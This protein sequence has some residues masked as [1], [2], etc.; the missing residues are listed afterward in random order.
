MAKV[1]ELAQL[2]GGKVLGDAT[3]V[4]RG[5][6]DLASAGEEELSFLA[7]PKYRKAFLETRAGAVL[8][9]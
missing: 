2:V 6:A 7:S 9:A 8:V 5:V 1:S 3:R 4:I